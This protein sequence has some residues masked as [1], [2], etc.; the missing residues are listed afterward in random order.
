MACL[1]T[2]EPTP[3]GH[4]APIFELLL[5]GAGGGALSGAGVGAGASTTRTAVTQTPSALVSEP[6]RYDDAADALAAMSLVHVVIDEHASLTPGGSTTTSSSSSSSRSQS[7][8]PSLL[9]IIAGLL[10]AAGSRPSSRPESDGKDKGRWHHL[11]RQRGVRRR[12]PQK[13][14]ER[15]WMNYDQNKFSRV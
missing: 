1:Q 5:G 6:S 14:T 15:M 10:D 7:A 4:R 8:S 9:P 2:R 12:W 13:T 3:D 11:H